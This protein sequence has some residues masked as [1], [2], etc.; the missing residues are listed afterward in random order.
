VEYSFAA[1][2]KR[3]F[4]V[5]T[6][7]MAAITAVVPMSGKKSTTGT[8]AKGEIVTVDHSPQRCRS[9]AVAQ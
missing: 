6:A 3:A 1:R 4:S 9:C 8:Q 7:T 5:V 2:P